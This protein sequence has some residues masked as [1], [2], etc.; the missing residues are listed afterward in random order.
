MCLV[1]GLGFFFEK[2]ILQPAF[3]SPRIFSAL[4]LRQFAESCDSPN[5]KIFHRA[6]FG[7]GG[8]SGE[9]EVAALFQDRGRQDIPHV[10][11]VMSGSDVPE[12]VE[13]PVDAVQNMKALPG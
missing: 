3:F 6:I 8:L 2:F 11:F 7:D 9:P 13:L 10:W 5:R 1:T 4:T 12:L